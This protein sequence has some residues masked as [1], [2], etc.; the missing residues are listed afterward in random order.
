MPERAYFFIFMIKN[1]KP[2]KVR[3]AIP[4][5]PRFRWIKLMSE[6][7]PENYTIGNDGGIWI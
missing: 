6:P 2:I 1:T 4:Y 7:M 3:Q 5:I